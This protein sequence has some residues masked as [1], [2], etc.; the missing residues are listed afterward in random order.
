MSISRHRGANRAVPVPAFAEEIMQRTSKRKVEA[1]DSFP[2][3][4]ER[5]EGAGEEEGEG[6]GARERSARMW[7]RR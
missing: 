2:T 6:E 1:L 4:G 7:S 3:A 5:G